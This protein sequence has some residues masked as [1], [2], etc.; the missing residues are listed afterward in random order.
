MVVIRHLTGNAPKAGKLRNVS[1]DFDG[2]LADSHT[3]VLELFNREPGAIPARKE[4]IVDYDM[5]KFL[6]Y[7][8]GKRISYEHLVELFLV[9]YSEPK[10]MPMVHPDTHLIINAMRGGRFV[11]L[12]SQTIATPDQVMDF[13]DS[14]RI[15]IDAIY[16]SE[17]AD[18]KARHA[19]ST[20]V[21]DQDSF[22][23]TLGTL[24]PSSVRIKLARPWSGVL[25]TDFTNDFV[26]ADMVGVA[27]L[28][29]DARS[30]LNRLYA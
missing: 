7:D 23:G 29:M 25:A 6:R 16:L 22:M 10:K 4:D 12:N 14:H 20:H 21:D 13:V 8:D 3:R 30:P 27:N 28:I 19:Q 1:F 18:E 9:A 26:A 5:T 2:V 11:A 15:P 17:N 24:A